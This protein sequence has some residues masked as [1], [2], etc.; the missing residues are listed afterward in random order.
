[1]TGIITVLPP[2]I[3]QPPGSNASNPASLPG[4]T[5]TFA[6][7]G[8]AQTWTAK[9]TFPLGMISLNAAD[10][11]GFAAAIPAPTTSTLGGVFSKAAAT[12]QFL[13]S[14]GTDGTVGQAQPAASDVSG[15]AASAT[16]DTTNAANISSGN[17]SVNRLNSGTGASATTFFAGDNSWK[18]P[19]TLTT[20]GS[21]G[22]ATFSGGALNVPQYV[23][24]GT[25]PLS[26]SGAN[27]ISVGPTNSGQLTYVSTTSLSFK[28]YNGDTLKINGTV[29]QIPSGGIAGLGNPT[30]VFLNGVAA[31]TL[32][33]NTTYLIYAF[34]NSGTI[35]A[36]FSTTAHATSSTAGNIGTE[37]KSGDDTR[38][39][40]G[41]V[42]TGGT[43]IYAADI[44]TA[45]WFNPV[46]KIA[47]I[48]QSS[49]VAYTT[50]AQG[51]V[52][53]AN[54][55]AHIGVVGLVSNSIAGQ[56]VKLQHQ[57]DGLNVVP[58]N[59]QG[60][61]PSGTQ[62]FPWNSSAL[63]MGAEGYHTFAAVLSNGGGSGTVGITADSFTKIWG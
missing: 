21:S 42:R 39:L 60:A 10:I 35:T 12:H 49:G 5:Y 50:T 34:N 17:L 46:E 15:L 40:I 30:S 43:V 1:M 9:Q 44:Q 45:S 31:Q 16:T 24:G 61:A 57:I 3:G 32:A 20:T 18:V 48:T 36:D 6:L 28:P 37:I 59:Q 25:Y 26:S 52:T 13:T 38:T 33:I 41:M 54:K 27:I 63:W 53:W 55:A 4:V 23:M 29:V 51:F 47:W 7:L 58:L 14:I 56:T 2:V 8:L 22:A 11:T 19:F 62:Q